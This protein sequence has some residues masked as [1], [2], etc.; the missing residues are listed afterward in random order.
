MLSVTA[1]LIGLLLLFW[2]GDRLVI[3]A[4]ATARNL[5]VSPVLMGFVIIGFATSAPEMFISAV[6][7]MNNAP[8]LALGN[9]VGSNIANLGMVLGTAVLLAPLA[10]HSKTLRHEF[11]LVL[12][13][14]G[15]AYLLFLDNDLS[16]IDA[17][18]LL[19]AL[20]ILTVWLILLG[21]RSSVSDPLGVEYADEFSDKMGTG[22]A[23]F[24]LIGGL[25]TLLVGA[26]LMVSG[27]TDAARRMGISELILGLTVVAVGTS[28]PELAVA[29]AGALKRESDL[30]IGNVLGSNIF[31]L[32]AVIGIAGAI[33]PHEL[34][35]GV[36]ALH[37]PLMTGMTLAVFI[38][39]YNRR[40][41]VQLT[42]P[43]GA[44]LLVTFLAYQGFVIW[45]ALA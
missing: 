29:V 22:K 6:A 2:G 36:L 10:V 31:N 8:A 21:M 1:I 42:R 43:I 4:G 33:Q 5:G 19:V 11:P 30:V 12:A 17:A 28:L 25:I 45:E 34:T 39:A 14:T 32:L 44:A 26:E 24:W 16:R 7:S 37:Y 18:L 20:A 41:K 27:A 13:A 38:L 23:I 3:G 35:T 9:A 40:A 15:F